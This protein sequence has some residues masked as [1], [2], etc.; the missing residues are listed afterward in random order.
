[1]EFSSKS[2]GVIVM[3]LTNPV[4]RGSGPKLTAVHE[5]KENERITTRNFFNVHEITTA[6][7]P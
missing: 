4:S 3:R 2:I 7:S 6:S 5:S 1:M